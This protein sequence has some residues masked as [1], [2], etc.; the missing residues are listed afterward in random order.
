ML[1]F[2]T[3]RD[4]TINRQTRRNRQ[5]HRNF[6]VINRT[7]MINVIMDVRSIAIVY[8]HDIKCFFSAYFFPMGLTALQCWLSSKTAI[9]I[10]LLCRI[11]HAHL[12]A[13]FNKCFLSLQS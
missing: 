7:A 9:C 1:Q 11:H 5:F 8:Y 3:F 6:R 10:G 2:I 12:Q 4:I 13:L